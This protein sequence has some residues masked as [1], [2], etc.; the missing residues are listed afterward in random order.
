MAR[1][2]KIVGCG[3][4]FGFQAYGTVSLVDNEDGV[5]VVDLDEKYPT[6]FTHDPA[7]LLNFSREGMLWTTVGETDLLRVDVQ[8]MPAF[9]TAIEQCDMTMP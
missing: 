3:S 2:F 6:T 7:K 1:A 9:L 8:D 4:A 5:I